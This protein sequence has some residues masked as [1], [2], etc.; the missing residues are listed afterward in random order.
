M[1]PTLP[2]AHDPPMTDTD[3]PDYPDLALFVDGAWRD[4]SGKRERV[5]E[6]ATGE[7]LGEVPHASARDL[8]DALAA[9]ARGFEVWRATPAFERQRVLDDAADR[10]EADIVTHSINMTREMGKPLAE[11]RAELTMAIETLR[12]FGE[13][14]KRAYGRLVP[15]RSADLRQ[16]VVREPVG[17]VVAFMAWNFPA[18]NVMRKVS[19][20]LAAGCSITIKASEETPATAL[21]IVRAFDAA[22]LPGGVLNA[23]FGVPDTVSRH[24]LGAGTA[25][26][27]SFTGSAPV[28][29][30]L[31]KLAAESLARVTLELGGHAPV[32]VFDDV[33][34]EAVAQAAVAAKFRNAG[35]VC[36]S[37]TRFY[38]QDG[39]HDAFV[40]AFVKATEAMRVGNGLEE[41]IA[42]GPL[43]A[44]RRLPV[45]D[46]LV[47]DATRRGARVLC[48]GTTIE[49]P[50][51]FY[52]PTVLV[53]VP[54]AAKMMNDEPFGP[55]A[56]VARFDDLADGL[57]K[58]N[59]LAAGLSA[60]AFT[61]DAAR[62]QA[63]GTGIDAGMV[64]IN[65]F[66]IHT[67]ETPFGGVD[68]SGYGSEASVEGLEVYQRTKV[69]TETSP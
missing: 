62:I 29:I 63:L 64:G 45:M 40:E 17:P 9:A 48:G 8:D 36:V 22:G 1:P 18:I 14:G 55:V 47:E 54:E 32:L 10:L 4:G 27:L 61:R 69:I 21:A 34:P 59:R 23:V 28:G 19:A 11:S 38:V 37:P 68:G 65:S 33:D 26:K 52:A 30:H 6:P 24:L 66:R 7:T 53:D 50:G 42:M 2:P 41:N 31:Q 13:E 56:P 20:A 25:K 60:Y 44:D 3:L 16:M 35:Q 49:G 39:V 15:S 5:L 12:W 67:P 58:A 51:S 57:A 46:D 43:I